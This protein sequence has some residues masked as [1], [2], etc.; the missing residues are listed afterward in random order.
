MT[1]G[2]QAAFLRDAGTVDAE[3]LRSPKAFVSHPRYP[4]LIPLAQV[5][6]SEAAG[7]EDDRVIRVIYALFFP[8]LVL[9]VLQAGRRW[10]GTRAALLATSAFLTVPWI[11]FDREGGAA[12][13][14]SDLSLACFLGGSLV[15]LLRGRPRAS[16]GIAAGL[17]A[18][19]V[20]VEQ[21][22][23]VRREE[24]VSAEADL[25]EALGPAE[26]THDDLVERPAGPEEVPAVEGA[27]GHFDQ[28]AAVRDEAKGSA[29]TP[30]K[31]EN[32]PQNLFLLEP[33]GF[34]RG[35]QVRARALIARLEEE[36]HVNPNTGTLELSLRD[37]DGYYV[38]I[39]ALSAA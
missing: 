28:G 7:T 36:P 26:D 6:A 25:V 21:E 18:G 14:Y 39:S 34:V 31:T 32:H 10:A 35:G 12:G 2:A 33:L 16:N 24:H 5:A 13:T 30:D 4:L 8:V 20:H 15:L 1:W 27:A 17:L 3:V 9:L 23:V 22:V 19:V 37:P 11:P 29:H 38:T